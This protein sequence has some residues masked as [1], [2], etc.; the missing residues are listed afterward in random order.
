ME[1]CEALL[2]YG[3]SAQTYFDYETDALPVINEMV[4]ERSKFVPMMAARW[5]RIR[6]KEAGLTGQPHEAG[7][8]QLDCSKARRELGW[9]GVLTPEEMVDLTVGWYRE[10]YENGRVITG[11]QLRDYLSLAGAR[12]LSW[13]N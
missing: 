8:L 7:L 6:V 3:G 13:T 5:D 4:A 11:E 1:L 10:F 2:H 9:H 12:G